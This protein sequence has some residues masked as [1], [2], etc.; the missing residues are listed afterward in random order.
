MNGRLARF[1]RYNAA[2]L[3]LTALISGCRS[4][5]VAVSVENRT[6]APV[7]LLEVDYPSASFGADSLAADAM[8]RYSIQVRGSG[9]VKVQYTVNGVQ[10]Q[11]KGPTMAEK[12]EGQ[13][14]IVLLPEGKA[15]FTPQ[16]SH[17]K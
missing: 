1:A 11:I 16:L 14:L 3:L 8:M 2:I 15:Q 6:G 13:F 7:Q 5:H 4:Y 17:T 9:P 12:D 10:K